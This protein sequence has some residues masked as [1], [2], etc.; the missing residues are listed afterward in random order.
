MRL[1]LSFLCLSC[2]L[3]ALSASQETSPPVSAP[4]ASPLSAFGLLLSGFHLESGNLCHQMPTNHWC[5]KLSP[6]LTQCVL[7]DPEN[8]R[9]QGMEYIVP[10][11]VFL[12]LPEEEQALWHSNDYEVRTPL[13]TWRRS[14]S[15]RPKTPTGSGRNSDDTQTPFPSIYFG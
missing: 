14:C 11:E 10:R 3:L 6:N 8:K 13:C 1:V 2:L 5:Q 15:E 12:S 7:L 9:F 4:A